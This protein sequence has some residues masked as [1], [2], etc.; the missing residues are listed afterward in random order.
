MKTNKGLI[1]DFDVVLPDE[2][3]KLTVY[4]DFLSK[5]QERYSFFGRN[6]GY[7]SWLQGKVL[8]MARKQCKK[9]GDWGKFLATIQVA[10]GKTMSPE[11]ARHCRRI[12]DLVEESQAKKK[13][14]ASSTLRQRFMSSRTTTRPNRWN[15]GLP[16]MLT[17][18]SGRRGFVT[19][20]PLLQCM[21]AR[22]SALQN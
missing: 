14:F 9:K 16:F 1:M 11:T 15:D 12:A 7:T 22:Y 18:L 4:V 20:T 3:Q 5:L 6:L 10:P 21:T 8:N 19:G 13:S 17:L 2:G